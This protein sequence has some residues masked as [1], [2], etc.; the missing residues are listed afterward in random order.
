MIT[1][2]TLWGAIFLALLVA[3]L[4]VASPFDAQARGQ[5][6][7]SGRSAERAI[8]ATEY[9]TAIASR[10]TSQDFDRISQMVGEVSTPNV[11]ATIQ[12]LESFQTRY[13]STPNLEAAGDYLYRTFSDLGLHVERDPFT[14][15]GYSSNN[16]VATLPGRTDPST[17]VIVGAHYDSASDNQPLSAPGADDDASGTAVVLELARV[18]R[19][20]QFDFTI[21]FIAFSAE[22]AGL[23]GS[24]HYA[25]NA[26]YITHEKILGMVNLDMVGYVDREPEDLDLLVD[27]TS[28]WLA[29]AFADAASRYAPLPTRRFS[30][31]A[32]GPNRSRSDQAPFWDFG[33]SAMHLIE[34]IALPNPNY[35]KTTDTA[36]TLNTAFLGA[37]ARATLATVAVLAQPVSA[38]APPTTVEVSSLRVVRGLFLTARIGSV[39]WTA[40]PTQAAGY[41]VYR[42]TQ[43]H[44]AYQRINLSPV[45]GTSFVDRTIPAGWTFY[46]VVKAV[47]ASG[48]EGN[49]SA[50]AV[51]TMTVR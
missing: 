50:P 26:R 23:R 47:D 17:V 49:A 33:Y 12:Y 42:S 46:Y 14:Y 44:A 8:T 10:S 6:A 27:E 5:H 39:T 40:T 38:P 22:E 15:A 37:V 1:R 19:N 29:D 48:T 51:T 41:N 13:F 3:A 4:P 36:S 28:G 20:Y 2:R 11:M 9:T 30:R 25:W 7:R 45:T 16:I 31:P 32:T 24:Q 43:P 35:H 21:K 18:L 34:D